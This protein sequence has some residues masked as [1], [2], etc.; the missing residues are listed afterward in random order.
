MGAK[1]LGECYATAQEAQDVA[2][3]DVE[4]MWLVDNRTVVIKYVFEGGAWRYKRIEYATS[5]V[6]NV[7]W[8]LPAASLQFPA[9]DVEDS[10][11]SFSDGMVLGWGVV[12]AMA[13]AWGF[14]KMKEQ[15]R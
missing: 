4:N 3:Q 13:I 14:Q 11:T 5:G 6:A 2:Y 15:V 9:C 12:L 7:Q 10:V 1:F 8:D